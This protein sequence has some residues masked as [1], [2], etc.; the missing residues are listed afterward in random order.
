MQIRVAVSFL[1]VQFDSEFAVIIDTYCGV[2][3]VDFISRK[4]AVEFDAGMKC[5]QF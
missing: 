2:Q 5:I 4:F 1:F 3:E